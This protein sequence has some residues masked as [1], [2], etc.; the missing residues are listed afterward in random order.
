MPGIEGIRPKRWGVKD[1]ALGVSKSRLAISRLSAIDLY[2]IFMKT[3]NWYWSKFAGI[4]QFDINS[5]SSSVS[6]KLK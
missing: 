1:P 3:T 6:V 2:L 5:Q 4:F